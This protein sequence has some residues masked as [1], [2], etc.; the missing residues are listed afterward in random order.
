MISNSWFEGAQSAGRPYRG[1]LSLAA[2]I[3]KNPFAAAGI[4]A[5]F[6]SRLAIS[7]L[8]GQACALEPGRPINRCGEKG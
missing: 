7:F 4:I 6:S 3:R 5:R 2:R 8:E 1:R